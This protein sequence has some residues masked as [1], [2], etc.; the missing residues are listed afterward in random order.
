MKAPHFFL[1]LILISG[2]LIAACVSQAPQTTEITTVK[3]AYIPLISNAPL[4]IAKE[5]GYFAQQGINVEFEKFQSGG[6]AFPALIN[7]DIAA[8]GGAISP[9]LYNAITRG[10]HVHIVADKGRMAPGFC[11]SSALMVRRDLYE[12]GM[13]RNVSDLK[14]RKVSAS[15][16]Q[17]LRNFPF[18]GS[19]KP[20]N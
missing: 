1:I 15:T 3:V 19:G 16:D 14:G 5:E 4:F 12:N 6:A 8:S 20:D 13:V 9:G 17:N 2:V 10:A 18:A 7:G 11:N